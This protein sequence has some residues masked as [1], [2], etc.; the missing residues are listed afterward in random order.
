MRKAI[1]ASALGLLMA[2]CSSMKDV[3][4][5]EQQVTRFHQMLDAG[6]FDAIYQASSS[7]MK[8]SDPADKFEA[9][10]GAVHR[11]LGAVTA[12]KLNGFNVNY[13]TG[14]SFATLNYGTTFAG[15]SATEQFVYR[16][17]NG[18]PQLA[19]Y[20]INSDALVLN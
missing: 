8:N 2:G 19:G 12:T 5:S 18:T 11:K 7:D 10:L 17:G 4:A 1:I 6:Q 13:T 16:L 20:H 14:G 15:G 9:F 3:Q